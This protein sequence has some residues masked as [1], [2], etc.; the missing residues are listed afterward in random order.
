M[1][2]LR[3]DLTGPRPLVLVIPGLCQHLQGE[4]RLKM[5]ENT[6]QRNVTQIINKVGRDR[7]RIAS[8]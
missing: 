2:D 4:I 7:D 3:P 1:E 8:F 6:D 5:L